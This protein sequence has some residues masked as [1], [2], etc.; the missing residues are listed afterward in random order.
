MFL[1]DDGMNYW[2][3]YMHAWQQTFVVEKKKKLRSICYV[4]TAGAAS[5]DVIGD[6]I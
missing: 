3:V 4:Q 5:F 1:V 2:L 6:V